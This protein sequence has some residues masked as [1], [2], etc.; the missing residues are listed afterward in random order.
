VG[1]D[2]ASFETV[3]R[4]F[5]GPSLVIPSAVFLVLIALVVALGAPGPT[6]PAAAPSVPT[7][8]SQ[9]PTTQPGLSKDEGVF[10][11]SIDARGQQVIYFIAQNTRH[12]IQNADLQQEQALNA[13]WPVRVVSPDEVLAYPEAAPIGGAKTGLL[14][15]PAQA[16]EPAAATPVVVEETGEP[17]FYVL[18]PGDNLTRLS[19]RYGITVADILVANGLANANRI[20]I[21]QSLAIPSIAVPA[22]AASPTPAAAPLVE[23]PGGPAQPVAAAPEADEVAE[24]APES[25]TY[26]VKPGDSAFL[27]ARKFG[28]DQAA[29]LAANGIANANRVYAGQSLQIPGA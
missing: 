9:L 16:A 3:W 26:L 18:K 1:R 14:T 24:A 12:S 6:P 13:L 29:L 21:G 28:V 2:R 27:I 20:F 23:A 22:D 17:T 4:P 11:V 5:H 7:L 19:E 10:L 8:K 25:T 15:P